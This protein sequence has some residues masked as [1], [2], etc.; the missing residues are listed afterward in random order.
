[1]AVTDYQDHVEG[2]GYSHIILAFTEVQGWFGRK[3][4]SRRLKRQIGYF[5]TEHYFLFL[6]IVE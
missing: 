5:V 1:M 4:L 2:F 3:E 6:T